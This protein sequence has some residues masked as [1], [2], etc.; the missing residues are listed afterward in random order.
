MGLALQI[1][2]VVVTLVSLIYSITAIIKGTSSSIAII[3]VIIG[4]VLI[5]IGRKIYRNK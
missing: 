5:R 2:G 3:L 4:G 1:I